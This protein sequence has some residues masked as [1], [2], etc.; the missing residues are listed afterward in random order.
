MKRATIGLLCAPHHI[1][2]SIHALVKRATYSRVNSFFCNIISI[3]ALVKRATTTFTKLSHSFHKISIHALVKRA[4]VWICCKCFEKAISIHALVKRATFC[5]NMAIQHAID[6]NPRPREEGD[7]SGD[8]GT[9]TA[10]YFNP[11]PREEG[12]YGADKVSVELG[13]FNP[14]PREEGDH[15]RLRGSRRL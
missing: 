5:Q 3:H 14:R 6:F 10:L 8:A 9:L 15:R 12:D 1:W 2:I 11:R 13:D 7:P 4:T